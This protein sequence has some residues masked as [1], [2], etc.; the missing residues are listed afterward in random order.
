MSFLV[1][2]LWN[3]HIYVKVKINNSGPFDFLFDSGAGASGLIIDSALASNIGLKATGKV[4]IG[5]T[6]GQSDF[7]ITDKRESNYR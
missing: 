2:D 3:N 5:A 7:L 1:F 6:G 4:T